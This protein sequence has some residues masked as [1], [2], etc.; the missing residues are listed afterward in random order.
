M[1]KP[2]L[3]IVIATYNSKLLQ[4]VLNSVFKQ[5]FSK[6]KLEVILVDGGS[7]DNTLSIGKKFGCRIINNPRTEPVY[8]KYLALLKSRGKYIMY[9]DHDEVIKN[10]SSLE[11][12]LSILKKFKYVKAVVG[13][14]YENPKG[15]PRIN[16]YVN[17]FGDPFSLF[18]YRL[19]RKNGFF[20][21]SMDNRY[22]KVSEDEQVNVYKFDITK[23]LP[24]FE[25][26]QGGSIFDRDYILKNY[27]K[28]RKRYEL[29]PHAFFYICIK[30]PYMAVVKND[31]ILHY[32][33]ETLRKYLKKIDWRIKNYIYHSE[34]IGE[35]G[36]SG[37]EKIQGGSF[38]LKKYLFV[39][40]SLSI[41]FPLYDSLILALSRGDLSY[42]LHLPLCLYTSLSIIINLLAKSMGCKPVLMNYDNTVR[43]GPDRK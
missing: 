20:V 24:P 12:K 40:Y 18:L 22:E 27:S 10:K 21:K 17:D 30:Y 15:Y 43:L 26:V 16:N 35:S 36:F 2:T 41:V 42:F 28:F 29:T 1:K 19:S 34:S 39:P 37:R 31:P 14:G 9:L 33:S 4:K 6:K 23:G 3:S 8:A 25:L 7:K 11:K 38:K 5:T 32:S 13:S